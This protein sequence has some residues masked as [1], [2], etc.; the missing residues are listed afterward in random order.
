M[1]ITSIVALLGVMSLSVERVVEIIKNMVPFLA[2]IH[3][4]AKKER[5]RRSALHFL[6]AFVGALIAFVAQ[7][8]IQ[9]LL[10]SIFKKTGEIGVF[11]CIVIG[12][13]ASGGSG[14]WNQ[15]LAI[16]EEIKKAK[17]LQVQKLQT[18]R[19]KIVD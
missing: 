12:L 19:G 6:A 5:W 13:L 16:V 1:E 10:P 4:D 18:D 8:Q 11:G 15:S 9:P 7:E 14:F 17:K 3:P 2:A